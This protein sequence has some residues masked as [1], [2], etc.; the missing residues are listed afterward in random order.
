MKTHRK[1][2]KRKSKSFITVEKLLNMG[3]EPKDIIKKENLPKSTVYDTVKKLRSESKLDFETLRVNKEFQMDKQ[4]RDNY[5]L[6]DVSSDFE[7]SFISRDTFNDGEGP[8]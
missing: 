2:A 5:Q 7:D 8:L 3:M 6:H 1:L 4:V